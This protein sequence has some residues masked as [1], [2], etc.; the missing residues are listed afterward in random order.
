MTTL[1]F[2]SI[3]VIN[4]NSIN[5]NDNNSHNN[6]DNKNN[7]NFINMSF[8]LIETNWR[9]LSKKNKILTDKNFKIPFSLNP[10]IYEI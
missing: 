6:N 8:V 9:H 2:N 7:N 5:N 3:L 4:N 10:N 1:L